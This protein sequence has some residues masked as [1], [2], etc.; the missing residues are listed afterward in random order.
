VTESDQLIDGILFYHSSIAES[1][2]IH[3][4]L[5]D[6]N[7][8]RRPWGHQETDMLKWKCQVKR[9]G[10]APH[11]FQDGKEHFLRKAVVHPGNIQRIM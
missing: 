6:E 1:V 4:S 10:V 11:L 3:T 9:N 5:A 8:A 2:E 7:G